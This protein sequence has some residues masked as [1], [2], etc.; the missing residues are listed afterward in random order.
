MFPFNPQTEMADQR[1]HPAPARPPDDAAKAYTRW[2][3]FE[4]V[5]RLVFEEFL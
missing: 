3:M 4:F 5:A 1:Q 2:A